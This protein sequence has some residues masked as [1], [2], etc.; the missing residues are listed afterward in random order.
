MRYKLYQNKNPKSL[1]YGKWYARGLH[2][3]MT[4]AEF[5]KHMAE[6]HCVYSE[7]T[8]RGVLLEMEIC[9]REQLLEGKAVYFDELGIFKLGLQSKG[10][11]T[12]AD[13]N[14][15]TH[16]PAVRMN[17]FLG[18]RFRAKDLRKDVK[19]TETDVNTVT[20]DDED[21]GENA[22][23]PSNGGNTSGSGSTSGN[24]S[25]SGNG[26]SGS[27]TGTVTPSGGGSQSQQGEPGTYR[28]VI[29]KY[30]NGTSTVTD[31]SEQEIN[32]N[33]NIAS[34]SNVNVSVVSGNGMEPIAKV[35][36]NRIALTE[37]DGVYVGSFQMPTKS[38]VLEVNS[39]PDEWD[40]ADEN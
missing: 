1:A 28:L 40:Y 18:A 27:G 38:T 15:R 16:V 36:G 4:F 30:G 34:G 39:E 6:H 8:I 21:D 23:Q 5:V 29:Y 37:N 13:F 33:D 19:L 24:G 26:N 17:L 10:V 11:A 9:L 2:E 32:S 14:V 3:V 35:N 7:A 12:P 31:D 22:T 20:Y 25:A